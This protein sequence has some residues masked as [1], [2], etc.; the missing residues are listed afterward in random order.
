MWVLAKGG[1]AGVPLRH[2]ESLSFGSCVSSSGFR[3]NVWLSKF[4]VVERG[5]CCLLCCQVGLCFEAA[6]RAGHD[7][8]LITKVPLWD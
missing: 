2:L 1:W 6:G 8:L 7:L 5:H 3:E 4:S